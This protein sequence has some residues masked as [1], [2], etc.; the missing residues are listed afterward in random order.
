MAPTLI[1]YF[2][3]GY[4]IISMIYLAIGALS[5]SLQDAQAYLMPVIFVITLPI[6][7]MMISVVQDPNGILPVTLSWIPLYT[8]FAMLGR[9]GSGVAL[10]EVIGTGAMLIVF[11]I[12]ETWLL[13]RL[14]QV[15]I[16]RTGQPP[17]LLTAVKS[18]FGRGSEKS[19]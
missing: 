11:V 19:A 4:L 2:V 16:L 10:S 3:T 18:M 1:F 9:F 8:P 15:S 17:A 7:F 6:V 5:T 13:G 12:L 14:F